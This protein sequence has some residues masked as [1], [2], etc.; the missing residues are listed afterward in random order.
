[1]QMKKIKLAVLAVAVGVTLQ[2]CLGSGAGW[3]FL[4]D[5]LGDTLWLRGVD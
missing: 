4:G 1:M 2:G 3:L 5:L